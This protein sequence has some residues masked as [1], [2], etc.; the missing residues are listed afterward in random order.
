METVLYKNLVMLPRK[1]SH[2][3]LKKK[4]FVIKLKNNLTFV[5]KN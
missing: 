1:N 5:K 4:K 2:I 3:Y